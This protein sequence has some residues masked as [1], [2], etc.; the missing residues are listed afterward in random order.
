MGD[1]RG[2]AWALGYLGLAHRS[3]WRFDEPID[4]LDLEHLAPGRFDEAL[5][6][7]QRALAINRE[8]GHR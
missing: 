3:M 7:F 8:V 5:R 6:F 4:R 2:E 1:R